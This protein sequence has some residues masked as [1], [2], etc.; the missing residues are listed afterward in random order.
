MRRTDYSDPGLILAPLSGRWQAGARRA[1]LVA[2]AAAIAFLVWQWLL[3]APVS[4]SDPGAPLAATPILVY[5]SEDTPDEIDLG[6][7]FELEISVAEGSG[8]GDRGGISVSFPGLTN[9]GGNSSSYDSAQGKVETISYTNGVSMVTYHDRG[10]QIHKGTDSSTSAADYLLVESDDGDWPSRISGGDYVWRTLK[11]RVTPKETGEFEVYYRV[12]LCG[13]GYLE[14]DRRPRP[15]HSDQDDQQRW[16]VNVITVDVTNPV[17]ETGDFAR[18]PDEDFDTLDDAGNDSPEGIW[19]EGT[20]MWVADSS[21]RKIYAYDL[22]TKARDSDK[23]FNTLDDAG[24]DNPRGIW[25]D[26]T[27]MWV[28]DYSDDK[29]YAYNLST[30][31][32]DSDK[33]FNTLEDAENEH[34]TGIWSDGTTMW[35][36][37]Y[38]DDKIYAYDLDSKGR[39]SSKDFNTLE[40]AENEGPAGIWSDGTTMWV[41][42]YSDEKIYAY[43]LNTKARVSSK[44]FDTLEEADNESPEG[45]WSDRT[46]VWVADSSDSKIY[47]YDAPEMA[48]APAVSNRAPS[49]SKVTPSSASVSLYVGNSQTFEAS[50]DDPDDNLTSWDWSIDGTSENS[51]RFGFWPF[52]N[53][54]SG[55]VTKEFT[56][57]FSSAGT[58]TVDAT[59]TDQGGRSGSVTWTVEVINRAPVISSASPSSSHVLLT[60]GGSQ[61]F[62]ATV[63]DADNNLKSWDW[64]VDVTSEDSGNWGTL[65]SPT[66]TGPVTKSFNHTFSAVGGYRVR[67]TFADTDGDS[68]SQEWMVQV[69]Q[70]TGDY[71]RDSDKDFNTLDA[72]GN[73]SPAGIWSDGTTMWVADSSDGVIYA[74]DLSTKARDSAKDFNTLGAAGNEDPE[75]IWSDG[76]TMWA[77]DSSDNKIYAYDLSTK[78]RDSAKDF[79]TLDAAGNGGPAGIWSDGTTMWVADYSDEKIYA[80]DLSTKARDSAKDFNTLEDAE[81]EGPEGI[82]SDGT[83]MW[84]ADYSDDKIYAYDLSTKARDFGKDFNT[85]HAAGNGRPSGIWSDGTT[86][87]VADSSDD[88]IYAYDGPGMAGPT[89]PGPTNSP[90]VIS[91]ATPSASSTVSL[92]AGDSQTFEATVSDPENNLEGWDWSVDGTSE[93]SGTWG[94]LLSSTPA[95]SVTR[96]F[97]HTFS[98]AG[99]YTVRATFTDAESESASEEWTV[100]VSPAA[101]TTPRAEITSC[102]SDPASPSVRDGWTPVAEVTNHSVSGFLPK[103]LY[104]QF[105]IK[106]PTRGLAHREVESTKEEV[107]VGRSHTFRGEL[108]EGWPDDDKEQRVE[109]GSHQ[110][111]LFPLKWFPSQID[112][113]CELREEDHL[114]ADDL[115]DEDMG[116]VAVPDFQ[117]SSADA[118]TTTCAP[119]R[120][121]VLSGEEPTLQANTEYLGRNKGLTRFAVEYWVHHEGL[122]VHHSGDDVDPSNSILSQRNS[123]SAWGMEEWERPENWID[124]DS[125]KLPTGTYILDCALWGHLVSPAYERLRPVSRAF[126]FL[127]AAVMAQGNPIQYI[128]GLVVGPMSPLADI[129]HLEREISRWTETPDYSLQGLASTEFSV[130]EARWGTAGLDI[131]R[132]TEMLLDGRER[133]RVRVSREEKENRAEER[134]AAPDFHIDGPELGQTKKEATRCVEGDQDH[135]K[136]L[137]L[138]WETTF[139]IPVNDTINPRDYIVWVESDLINDDQTNS[140]TVVASP[141]TAGLRAFYDATGGPN[142]SNKNGWLSSDPIG[143]WYGVD[144]NTGGRVVK[145]DLR[146]SGQRGN[147]LQGPLP[148]DLKDTLPFLDTLYLAGNGG[149]IECVRED[150]L[151]GVPAHDLTFLDLPTCEDTCAWG[152]ALP[153]P[154]NQGLV[155]DCEAL[156]SARDTLTAGRPGG[157]LNWSTREPIGTWRGVVR[158]GNPERVIRLEIEQPPRL[159][160]YISGDIAKLSGLQ[161]LTLANAGLRGEIPE[162]LKDLASLNTLNLQGNQLNGGIP[163]ELSGLTS[164]HTLDLSENDLNRPIPRNL[165]ELVNLQTLRL[166]GNQF[167]GCIPEGLRGVANNDLGGLGLPFC[168]VLLSGLTISPGVLTPRFDSGRTDYTAE[169]GVSRITVTPTN[170]HNATFMFLDENDAP[171]P[172]ADGTLAGHQ[173]ELGNGVTTIGVKVLSQDAGASHTYTIQVSR[174]GSLPDAPAIVVPITPGSASLTVSWT[175]PPGETGI[176][177]YDLRYIESGS[178]PDANWT[179]EESVWTSGSGSPNYQIT[180]L[181]NGTHYDVQVRTVNAAGHGFWSA[182]ATGTPRTTPGSP[183]I[184]SLGPGDSTLAVEWSAPATNGGAE[185]TGYDL[186]FI[187]SDA[188]DKADANWTGRNN[189]WSS[190]ALRYDLEGLTNGIGYDVQ[191][192]GVNPAGQG[193]WSPTAAGKPRTTPGAPAIDSLGPG[194]STLAVEWSAPTTDGGAEVI[195]YDLR[196]I[197]SDAPDKADA[198][199]TGRNNIWSSG[200]LRYDLGGLTNGVSYDVLVRVV[201][202]VGHGPWSSAATG[203]ARTTPGAPVIDSLVLG[204]GA[205]SVGWSDPATDGGAE[206]TGYDLRYIRSDAPDRA[207]ANWAVRSS[208][209]NSGPLRYDLGGLTDGVGYNVQVRAANA[210]G[211]GQW[212]GSITVTPHT[213]ATAPA[214]VSVA[215]GDGTLTISWT[216]PSDTGGLNIQG[217][218]ARYIPAEENSSGATW[219]EE[220]DVWTLGSL[221]HTVTGLTNG[222]RYDLE[223]R[224]ATSAGDGPWSPTFSGTPKTTPD[225]PI[226]SL[227]VPDGSTLTV[228]WD[229]PANTG[230]SAITSYDLRYIESG[231]IDKADAN[232]T[233]MVPAWSTGPLSYAFGSLTGGTPYDVQVRAVNASGPGTWSATFA[234]T[235]VTMRASRSFAPAPVSAGGELEVTITATGYGGFGGV[236]ETLPMGFSYVS[237]SLSDSAVTVAGQ[238]VSFTLFGDTAFTYTVAAPGAART[239]SFSGVP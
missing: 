78:A 76:T 57:T 124:L 148:S 9:T 208:I 219:T 195:G 62:A 37:D 64:S 122:R 106:D 218:D 206:V 77:A 16:A 125:R 238:E 36:A 135:D 220:Q 15:E 199:W 191:V 161:V 115:V 236:V 93:D 7:S 154:N 101:G 140:L 137:S 221:E 109:D 38:S 176:T 160:G 92:T 29:I 111:S 86:V 207:D 166:D 159:W 83:T 182:V 210:A 217:Y 203:K 174:G 66:P 69:V 156:L 114:F 27:T 42:D 189:I 223:L 146:G 162:E 139:D 239:Y 30:R 172:D 103:K 168:D 201:N 105:T 23:D 147:G 61:T 190:G 158:E 91:N 177:S 87:W 53:S 85:L 202:A 152:E 55:T 100:E 108:V 130:V 13:D 67:A 94:T 68:D 107:P 71:K 80:Y 1:L 45:L 119:S 232:W 187:R 47:A 26:D 63:S 181:A 138:C 184:D 97:S 149:L 153:D 46:T 227:I 215:A 157:R 198:N 112:V 44:D 52:Y 196:F 228:A 73:G 39:V 136:Y 211:H 41:V 180:G 126:E 84:V 74:Y 117:R 58:Y 213:M 89:Q 128:I 59:F 165:T 144:T 212:S 65:F 209:W 31:A 224:A 222:V 20:T 216:A 96:S 51:G 54:P 35:V 192:R 171:I 104:V 43:N 121:P 48:P 183:A 205:L 12:W 185:V 163:R 155:A 167:S 10:D 25:S 134:V 81:N 17:T 110:L 194:D 120:Q 150:L 193:L 179:V 197:R 225:A 18:D 5:L 230:G 4:A 123:S 178:Q 95:G 21:D 129:Q 113:E 169:V 32:R 188:P 19:S 14:C 133:I 79:N 186:R 170:S 11:L 116:K 102:G 75:G 28:A 22:S 72:A 200:A 131:E 173:V 99:T 50:A 88:K 8:Q 70:E 175:A 90:P 145:L 235:P 234:G 231:A 118:K 237:S 151:L 229:A 98:S 82:W 3:A 60:M 6:G 2:V 127:V 49:V 141:D 164:L 24:N 40:D 56:R 33:D 142:W 233:E 214:I 204:D 143:D 132:G 34:P 226:I